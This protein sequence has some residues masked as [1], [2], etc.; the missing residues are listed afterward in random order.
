MAEKNMESDPT[1]NKAI[2]PPTDTQSDQHSK[3]KGKGILLEEDVTEVM[4]L[5]PQ[6]LARPLEL[7][8]YRK[9]TSINVPDPNPTGLCFILLD[10]QV[11]HV[12]FTPNTRKHPP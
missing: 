8:V 9:W 3:D 11:S 6:D 5:K 12:R 1:I 4:N 2:T 7:K 10:K